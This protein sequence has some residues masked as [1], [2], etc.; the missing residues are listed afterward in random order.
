MSIRMFALVYMAC[1]AATAM[2]IYLVKYTV[3]NIQ[4]DVDR[5]QHEGQ[6]VAGFGGRGLDRRLHRHR[7]VLR[8]QCTGEREPKGKERQPVR[9]GFHRRGR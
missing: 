2:G 6:L 9:A 1:F 7:A 4:R 3:Q 5:G 8:R